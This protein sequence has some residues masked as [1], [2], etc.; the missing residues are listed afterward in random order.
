MLIEDCLP[1][2]F[3]TQCAACGA[4]ILLMV[5]CLG[6]RVQDIEELRLSHLNSVA[7]D[8]EI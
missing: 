3:Q 2:R 6:I 5:V 8:I 4:A 7:G 1:N